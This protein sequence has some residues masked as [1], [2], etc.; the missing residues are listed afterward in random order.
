M[1][2]EETKIQLEKMRQKGFFIPTH[3]AYFSSML[4]TEVLLHSLNKTPIWNIPKR[5]FIIKRMFKEVKGKPYSIQKPFYVTGGEYITIG[6]NFYTN[7]NCTILG[8]ADVVIGDNVWLG[9]N[10]TITTIGHPANFK[11][12]RIKTGKNS[13]EPEHRMNV[14]KISPVKIGNDVWICSGSVICAGVT[15]G[16]NCIIGAGSIVT[17]D[18]P[19]NTFACGV[20]CRVVKTLP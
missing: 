1:K 12:R 2:K 8:R 3:K 15:I 20:P 16:D 11:A 13:F 9:P 10:V 5:N 4:K 17:G 14:E 19:P 6:K 7:F 18:I